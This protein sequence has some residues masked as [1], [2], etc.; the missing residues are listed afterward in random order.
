MVGS[1]TENVVPSPSA[2]RTEM[3]PP[4][5]VT[6]PWQIDRP[7]PVPTPGAL[8]VKNGSKMRGR[9]SGRIPS[10]LSATS[11]TALSFASGRMEILMTFSGARTSCIDCA[12]L[13]SRLRST[14]SSRD[15]FAQMGR[16]GSNDV[17]T[18][19]RWRISW[20]AMR[21]ADC[22]TAARSTPCRESLSAREKLRSSRT[23][24]ATRSTPPRASRSTS[25]R[26]RTVSGLPA[27]SGIFRAIHSR[28][29]I[30]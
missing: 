15:S 13:S 10:P 20:A 5:E 3:C 12:A 18:V 22:A 17:V 25:A 26:S 2:L 6:M 16:T 11:S 4:R 1:V 30:T 23:M 14:C 27:A 28:L 19:A 8:V 29:S 7:R 24:V 21:M 9:I